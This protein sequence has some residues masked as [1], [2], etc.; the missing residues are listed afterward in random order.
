MLV[1]SR[2]CPSPNPGSLLQHGGTR[3]TDEQQHGKDK[4]L[5]GNPTI[6]AGIRLF[7]I[8]LL[9]VLLVFKENV[10]QHNGFVMKQ[11]WVTM[12]CSEQPEAGVAAAVSACQD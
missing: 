6:G 1:D 9:L 3:L 4:A 5:S 2:D 12:S 7:F 11:G 10:W 8:V